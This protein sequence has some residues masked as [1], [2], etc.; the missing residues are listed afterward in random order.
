MKYILSDVDFD[1]PCG[2]VLYSENL[3][4]LWDEC[5]LCG[6]RESSTGWLLYREDAG[7]FCWYLDLKCPHCG[8]RGSTWKREWMPL[9]DEVLEAKAEEGFDLAAALQRL[10]GEGGS[11]DR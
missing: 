9:I 1:R 2:A 5:P 7:D 11:Q 6:G 8:S 4:G 10:R 3:L